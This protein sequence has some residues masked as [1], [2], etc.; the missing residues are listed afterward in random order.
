MQPFSAFNILKQ[1]TNTGKWTT[2]DKTLS[3]NVAHGAETMLSCVASVAPLNDL[4]RER[5]DAKELIIKKLKSRVSEHDKLTAVGTTDDD[6]LTVDKE[7]LQV[8][9]MKAAEGSVICT[10]GLAQSQLL[11]YNSLNGGRNER[12]GENVAVDMAS[13]RHDAAAVNLCSVPNQ[14]R[15]TFSLRA[16][17]VSHSTRPL[18]VQS[19]SLDVM[20][21]ICEVA[22]IYQRSD[23]LSD[24]NT[25]DISTQDIAA[26]EDQFDGLKQQHSGVVMPVAQCAEQATSS[27]ATHCSG[28]D[29][30]KQLADVSQLSDS[31]LEPA[32]HTVTAA[33]AAAAG[34][35][36]DTGLS[37]SVQTRQ[38]AD[39]H[40]LSLTAHN[41][42]GNNSSVLLNNNELDVV[43]VSNDDSQRL[44]LLPCT[45]DVDVCSKSP[46]DNSAASHGRTDKSHAD[47]MKQ[48]SVNEEVLISR[49]DDTSDVDSESGE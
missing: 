26:H 45:V 42:A 29:I 31:I 5:V 2:L 21:L 9:C 24:G 19:D 33:A 8:E 25:D 28:I 11:R 22:G 1:L 36:I 43:S 37:L 47:D 48:S 27:Q 34:T 17:D 14:Q 20:N 41:E 4:N 16:E 46:E 30:G 38:C 44:C 39:M 6:I 40:A 32:S 7:N 3:L 35:S 15:K 23:A 13:G 12:T 49:A 10:A 18:Q